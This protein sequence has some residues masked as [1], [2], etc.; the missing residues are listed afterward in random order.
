VRVVI[1]ARDPGLPNWLDTDGHRE[2]MMIFR[3]SRSDSPPPAIETGL[4]RIDAL[5]RGS[6]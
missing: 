3:L 2:G 5:R 4:V 1:A 6:P